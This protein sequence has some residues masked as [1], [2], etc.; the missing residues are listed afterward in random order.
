MSCS[1]SQSV[2]RSSLLVAICIYE[3]IYETIKNKIVQICLFYSY[4][5]QGTSSQVFWGGGDL[6]HVAV[7]VMQQCIDRLMT[8]FS[9]AADKQQG[10]LLW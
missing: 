6:V 5:F 2:I 7:I 1:T 3:T 4:P 9:T 8:L 10:S